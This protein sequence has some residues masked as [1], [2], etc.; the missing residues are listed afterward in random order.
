VLKKY[1]VLAGRENNGRKRARQRI[2][3]YRPGKING[4][5]KY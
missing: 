1:G 2:E 5:L 3:K 4:E